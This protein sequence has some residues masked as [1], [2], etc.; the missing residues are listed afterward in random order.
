MRKIVLFF[1]LILA[2]SS[3]FAK[4][5]SLEEA[6]K[7]ALQNNPEYL[8]KKFAYKAA[9]W[10]A[11][12]SFSALLPSA[13]VSA[14]QMQMKPG[15]PQFSSGGMPVSSDVLNTRSY[16]FSVNQPL[17]LGGKIWLGYKMS[18]D[19][20]KMAK[21]DFLNQKLKTTATAEEKYLSC[22]ET[23]D[24]LEISQEQ[25]R[26]ATENLKT[27]KIKFQT[28]IISKTELLKFQADE[29]AKESELIRAR[30]LQQ[31][32]D[33]D[34]KNFLQLS[35][36][37]EVEEIPENAFRD[38]ME[39][40]NGF[41]QD[42]IERLTTKIITVGKQNNFSLKAL[43]QT[44]KI[45]SGGVSMASG[46]FLPTL[47]LNFSDTWSKNWD[48]NQT[49]SNSDYKDTKQI[50]LSASIPIFPLSDNFAALKK[51]K[52]DL[53]KTENDFISAKSGIET[54]LEN[55]FLNLVNAVKNIEASELSRKYSQELSDQLQE[56]FRQ[57]LISANDLLD[58]NV[59]LKAAAIN[60]TK[61]RFAFIKAKSALMQ[62][63]GYENENELLQL[64]KM[65]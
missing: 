1:A 40:L 20:K 37:I 59:M 58:A 11:V 63:L 34:L 32:S 64:L 27:A 50:L 30:R 2:I 10:S 54:A 18:S 46:N 16:G 43:K 53:K 51:A 47:N 28:G 48:E 24:L 31:I 5:I 13:K 14:S 15:T 65:K 6:K 39:L 36:P 35:E 38:L 60:E 62:L 22:L 21:Y 44:K 4:V 49:P 3:I 42:E 12:K 19:S 7:L 33:T 56:K 45:A 57:G 41:A 55:G 29:A 8:S 25:L 26:L 9:K 23:R 61:S 52:Y 17:F